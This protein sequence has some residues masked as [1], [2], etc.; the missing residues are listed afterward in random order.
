MKQRIAAFVFQYLVGV[1]DIG[2][3]AHNYS[4]P[5]ESHFMAGALAGCGVFMLAWAANTM[6]PQ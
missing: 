3:A 5:G 4:R 6:Y 2:W 1:I